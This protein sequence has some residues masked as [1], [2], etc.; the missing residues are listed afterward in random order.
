[1]RILIA[2]GIYPP[3]IGGPAQY[4]VGLNKGFQENG[5]QTEIVHYGK[6]KLFPTGVRHFLFGI[7]MVRKF[8]KADAV[9][10]L[11]TFSVG[12]PVAILGMFRNI[13]VIVRIGG[14]FL[15]EQY[16]ER[17]HDLVPLPEFYRH[18]RK[19]SLKEKIIFSIT[20]FVLRHTTVVFSTGWL[21]DI[22]YEAYRF[23]NKN[24]YV[25]E[26]AI[27]E[28]S[29]SN[30]PK[31]KNFLLYSRDIVLKNKEA[32][33]RAFK[34]AQSKYP[35]IVLEEGQVSK[36][37]LLE[38]MKDAYAVVLPSISEVSPNYILDALRFGKPF[39][40]TKYSGYTEWLK[41]YGLIV[42][43]LDEEDMT[44][45][46]ESLAAE[47]IYEVQRKKAEA[48]SSV[49]T[50]KEISDDFVSLIKDNRPKEGSRS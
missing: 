38:K 3:E 17:T 14:D 12:F 13:P 11:D 34:K 37:E 5:H 30:E 33:R 20:R 29:L 44:E 49:R 43:P 4:A 46:I 50:Y 19:L 41:E 10:A 35:H 2:T 7:S 15:W 16:I 23:N 27:E 24:A 40:L 48:F 6:L 1:M 47:K 28:K 45:K 42:N 36:S 21:R 22:W 31:E 25:I 39:I 18:E 26:N 32:F 9:I 8:F